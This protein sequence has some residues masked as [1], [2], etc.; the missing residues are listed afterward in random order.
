MLNATEHEIPAEVVERVMDSLYPAPVERIASQPDQWLLDPEDLLAYAEGTLT[1]FLLK[2]DAQ[3]E[4][5]TS[6][7]LPGPTLVKG[8]PGSG[9]STIALYR[10][11]NLVQHAMATTGRIPSVLFTTYTNALINSSE[12]LLRQ[13]L[14]EVLNLRPEE[15][16]PRQIR[17]TTLHK[18]V[19]WIAK[20]SG[21]QF[22]TAY[23]DQ[24]RQALYAARAG[25]KAREP[26]VALSELGDEY[27]LQE[28]EWI[29]EGQNCRTEAD[30][31]AAYQAGRG[32]SFNQVTRQAVWQLYAAYRDHLRAQ[33]HY[34]WSQLVQLALEQVR[35][36]KFSRRWDYV[37]VDEMQDLT[38]AA[39]ALCLALC[40]EPGGLYLAAD[41][42]QSLYNRGF[43]WHHVHQDVNPRGRILTL[44][45][46][47]RNTREIVVAANQILQNDPGFDSETL[48][49][50]FRHY[51]A[52]PVIYAASGSGDQARWI[53]QQVYGAARE[54]RLPLN[55]AVVLVYSSS[56]GQPLA[57]ALS[58]QGLPARFVK[59]S[60]FDLEDPALKVTTLHAAK[61]LEFPVVAIA[62]VEAGRLPRETAASDER[63]IAAFLQEQRRLFYV[64]C[65]RA[66]RYLFLTYDRQVPSPFL[67]DLTDDYWMRVE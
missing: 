43:R 59:S 3:Q 57:R 9:K 58:E 25:L 23:E 11:R 16:L 6:W 54:L 22:H 18:T 42:N 52:P 29:I 60:E 41:A 31:L 20:D 53:A 34:S 55:S 37:I 1:A 36:G 63:E 62:H 15:P 17:I 27:L 67:A 50:E 65:T 35:S 30:Y 49:Q 14:R 46:N 4:P 7:A 12:S 10:V 33:N 19:R 28:F 48:E 51:G 45:R 40:R 47:F 38:P 44:E 8:G 56:V 13:L 64:G 26:T 21:A 39:V 2:L 66:M 32:I 24:C 61:G 5:F